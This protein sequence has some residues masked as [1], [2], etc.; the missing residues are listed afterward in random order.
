MIALNGILFD[1]TTIVLPIVGCLIFACLL[2]VVFIA[3]NP[4]AIGWLTELGLGVGLAS[5]ALAVLRWYLDLYSSRLWRHRITKFLQEY[6]RARDMVLR[7]FRR[8]ILTWQIRT[9]Y[10]PAFLICL[11]VF[12]DRLYAALTAHSPDLSLQEVAWPMWVASAVVGPL[13]VIGWLM[14][15]RRFSDIEAEL[16][17]ELEQQNEASKPPDK[18]HT[19]TAGD[20]KRKPEPTRKIEEELL[21]PS[22]DSDSST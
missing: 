14:Q 5:L 2:F 16:V 19:E 7:D 11:L 22:P 3:T 17:K 20:E 18:D 6:R 21:L 9:L 10:G 4:T 1:F 13:V 12:L 8:F 15:R